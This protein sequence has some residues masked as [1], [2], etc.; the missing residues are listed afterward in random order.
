MPR[1]DVPYVKT[2]TSLNLVASWNAPS[3]LGLNFLN[4]L[5]AYSFQ[6]IKHDVSTLLQCNNAQFGVLATS[7]H[8]KVK[9]PPTGLGRQYRIRNNV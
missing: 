7:S 9:N 6:L 8:L 1:A 4:K 3:H 5:N 2:V